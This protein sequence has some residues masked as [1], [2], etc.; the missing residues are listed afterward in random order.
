MR[1]VI[2]TFGLIA[3]VI[4]SAFVGVFIASWEKNGKIDIDGNILIGYAVMVIAMSTVFF[5]IK[6]YRDNYQSGAIRFWK[7]FQVGL[8]ITLVAS[9]MYAITWETY[10]Q[11]D[12]A[13]S[14]AFIDYYAQCQLDEEKK[15]GASATKIAEAIED[16]EKL[17]RM[18]ANPAIRFSMTL[19]EV[20]PVGVIITLISAALLRKKEF[21]PASRFEQEE[22]NRITIGNNNA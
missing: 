3:G 11:I 10:T 21:L 13:S 1:K 9:L 20:L 22:N 18:Y 2:L 19:M 16:M 12:P 17:K 6:S 7:G 5:G 15:K 14:M 4:V 8:L